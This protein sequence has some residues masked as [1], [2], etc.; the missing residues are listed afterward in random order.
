MSKNKFNNDAKINISDLQFDLK[1]IKNILGNER[2]QHTKFVVD[3]AVKFAKQLNVD[4]KKV[5]TAALFHDIA[6]GFSEEKLRYYIRKSNWQLDE[7]ENNLISV[8]HAPA[9]AAYVKEEFQITDIKILEA[10]R[11]HTL[12]H[13]EMGKVAHII[14]AADFISLDRNFIGL[15]DIRSVIKNNFY[16][17]LY[18]ITT[19]IINYQLEQ[20]N[21]VHPF[22]NALRNKLLKR[23]DL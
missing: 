11:Y 16:R 5:V 14:Y 20:N 12:G 19:N 8:L 7:L 3:A 9:G 2:Y 17:G 18:L 10:I 23:S 15:T 6:K 21:L 1:K 22:S 4:L 13:P